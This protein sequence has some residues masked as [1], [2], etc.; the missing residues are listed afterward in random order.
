MHQRKS[1]ESSRRRE[2]QEKASQGDMNMMDKAK[3]LPSKKNSDKG[4]DLP[5]V[6]N[7]SFSSL[8]DLAARMKINIGHDIEKRMQMIDIIKKLEDARYSIYVETIKSNRNT[9]KMDEKNCQ[10]PLDMSALLPLLTEDDEGIGE[11]DETVEINVSPKGSGSGRKII[12]PLSVK[13]KI[14]F[15]PGRKSKG[16][17]MEK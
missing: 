14:R 11:L 2:Y 17:N 12:E 4:N 15:Q 9:N 16:K 10:A 8:C 6:L 13:P 7:S 1:N 3:D 5:T